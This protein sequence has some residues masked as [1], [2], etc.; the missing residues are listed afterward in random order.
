MKQRKLHATELTYRLFQCQVARLDFNCRKHFAASSVRTS[1]GTTSWPRHAGLGAAL[2]V[3]HTKNSTQRI[4][5]AGDRRYGNGCEPTEADRAPRGG[6][7][8]VHKGTTG[9]PERGSHESHMN[10]GELGSK[11]G[12]SKSSLPSL[13]SAGDQETSLSTQFL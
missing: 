6:V 8:T 12:T 1:T 5:G 7:S 9:V 13:G 3:E 2:C 4:H 10:A 11:R